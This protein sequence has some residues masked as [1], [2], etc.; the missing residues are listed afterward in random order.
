M[1]MQ[2]GKWSFNIS[3]DEFWNKGLFDTKEEAEK[4]AV[5]YGKKYGCSEMEVGMCTLLPLPVYV[6]PDDILERLNEQYAEDAGGEYDDDIYEDVKKEDLDWFEEEMSR[7]V[8]EFHKRADI[9][10]IWYTVTNI[11]GIKIDL[12]EQSK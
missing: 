2:E 11:H 7:I 6:D 9:K 3:N 10:S 4:E 1:Q 8:H 12:S 5:E